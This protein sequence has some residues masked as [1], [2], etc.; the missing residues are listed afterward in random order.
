MQHLV[1]RQLPDVMLPSTGGIVE[2]PA[3]FQG[4]CVIFCYPWSGRPGQPNPPDWDTIPGA[5]GSTP[6]AQAYSKAYGRFRTL[7]MK[8]FGLSFQSTGWQQ[9]FAR[10]NQLNFAL[11]SDEP[12][13]FSTALGL[14]VFATG[15]V[16][17][18]QRLTLVTRD[19]VIAALRFPVPIPGQDAE[20]TLSL[21]AFL[22][23]GV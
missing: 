15:G 16:D 8:L 17:Y 2:M 11:L 6:Q 14:P 4:H 1:G 7:G 5:H 9:E 21:C 12:R 20:E 3:R 23:N 18:L 13:E 19:G 22:L 10:R